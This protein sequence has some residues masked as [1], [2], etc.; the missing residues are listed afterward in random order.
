MQELTGEL[1]EWFR[2]LQEDTRHCSLPS[3]PPAAPWLMGALLSCAGTTIRLRELA[4]QW[5]LFI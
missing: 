2:R 1:K 3:S 4:S 5:I